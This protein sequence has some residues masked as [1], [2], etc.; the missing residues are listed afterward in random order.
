MPDV[1]ERIVTAAYPMFVNR[2]IRDVTLDEIRRQAEVTAAQ[3]SAEFASRD[4]VAAVCLQRREAIWTIG[5]VEAG[6]RA[7]GTT[8]EECLLAIFDVFDDWFH[9]DDYE[10]C[11]FVNV[12]LEMGRDHPLGRASCEHLEHIRQLVGRLAA[13]AELDRVEEFTLSCHILMKGSIINAAEG[14]IEA[15]SRSKAMARDLVARHQPVHA[16]GSSHAE[17]V[18]WLQLHGLDADAFTFSGAEPERPV[19]SAPS[20]AVRGPVHADA[21]V[22]YYLDFDLA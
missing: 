13:E 18:E 22:A 7:R 6:A 9:R 10:A 2:G 21:D 17:H 8:P 16:S 5:V 3:F 1:R 19:Q 14:D 11:T 4:D 15:A 20:A 12:L